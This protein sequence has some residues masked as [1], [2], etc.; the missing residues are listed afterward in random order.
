MQFFKKYI[1]DCTKEIGCISIYRQNLIKLN[2]L[3][4]LNFNMLSSIHAY[5]NTLYKG[6]KN[7]S[8][9]FSTIVAMAKIGF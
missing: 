1:H 8:I 7:N 2:I 5:I 6:L 9:A 4:E 3:Y